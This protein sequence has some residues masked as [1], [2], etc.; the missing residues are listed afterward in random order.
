MR[1]SMLTLCAL[2]AIGTLGCDK[3]KE[4]IDK[5]RGR[6]PSTATHA[7]AARDTSK[8][9]AAA[10]GAT[11]AAGTKAPASTPTSEGAAPPPSSRPASP[12]RDTP[13]DSPDTGT[14]APGMAEREVY[15][16]WGAP[17]AVRR[18]GEYTYLFFRNGCERSCGTM[19]LVTLQNGQVVDAIVRWP[20]HAYSGQSSSP[21]GKKH[22]PTRGGDTLQIRNP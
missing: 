5:R 8:H 11:P 17:A 10:P 15:S 4:A 3:I 9:P 16:L 2:V 19:D 7:P 22:G 6:I 21:P 13:Y 14:V 12:V 20:G 1:R 18:S